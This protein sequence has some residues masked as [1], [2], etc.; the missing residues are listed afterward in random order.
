MEVEIGT[1][2]KNGVTKYNSNVIVKPK[3]MPVGRKKLG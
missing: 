1:T 3:L 2:G